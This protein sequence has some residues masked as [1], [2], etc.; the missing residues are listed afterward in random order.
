MRKLL[1]VSPFLVALAV[2]CGGG[3]EAQPTPTPTA[4]V[5]APTP[6][7]TPTPEA[8]APE[9]AVQT[10]AFIQDGDIWLVNA[11]GTDRRRITN[12]GGT[13][14]EV[15]SFEW[16]A[17]GQEIAWA[18]LPFETGIS[19]LV[20]VDGQVLWETELRASPVTGV[21]WSPDGQ[22]VAIPPDKG[23]ARIEDR[24][25]QSVWTGN[26]GEGSG[27]W[28]ADGSHFAIVE[29]SEIVVVS[30][31][32]TS[33][34]RLYAGPTEEE[35]TKSQGACS[36]EDARNDELLFG[37]PVFSPGG[38]SVLVAVNCLFNTGTGGI[39]YTVI[40]EASLDGLTNR[41]VT[42]SRFHGLPTP[43]F[44]PDG[45]RM[46]LLG[47]KRG[48]YCPDGVSAF[49]VME[50]DILDPDEG[51]GSQLMPRGIA[52]LVGDL[53]TEG[54]AADIHISAVWSPASDAIVAS[55][56]ATECVCF[57]E[58]CAT[59]QL[60]DRHRVLTGGVY[61]L[62]IDGVADE[63]VAD[64][65]SGGPLSWSP[66]GD[67]IAYVSG[68]DFIAYYLGSHHLEPESGKIRVFDL[69]T[70]DVTDLGLGDSPAWRPLPPDAATLP[71]EGEATDN[72]RIRS[73]ANTASD[74]VGTLPKSAKVRVYGEAEGEEAEP[75]SGNR[76]WY[77][78]I[79]GWVYSAFVQR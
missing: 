28:S 75:G 37:R 58:A 40:Y 68:R 50:L 2:A 21:F 19:G 60:E 71:W 34:S 48:E 72:L 35:R 45:R 44:S 55:F 12:F 74:T 31:D 22:L 51:N 78:V 36:L 9:P 52:Q 24:A 14:R 1:L 70:G 29:G 3:Q 8:A 61:L 20:S 15:A 7:L 33:V 79:G 64:E 4:E 11:D 57:E 10:L 49:G 26:G 76:I 30:R 46:A 39:F 43:V 59:D 56:N 38:Q 67:L 53:A 62:R 73:E 32:G 16:L 25:G 54:P 69:V 13:D 41:P 42:D 6:E 65:F 63:T 17:N 18:S 27:S 47:S 66:S 77:R 5:Q 23:P